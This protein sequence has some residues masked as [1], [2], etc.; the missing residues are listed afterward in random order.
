MSSVILRTNG[1]RES[2]IYVRLMTR[3]TAVIRLFHHLWNPKSDRVACG[4]MSPPTRS[5]QLFPQLELSRNQ[6][7][8]RWSER[9]TELKNLVTAA[10][11]QQTEG[12][13][14]ESHVRVERGPVQMQHAGDETICQSVDGW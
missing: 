4:T 13:E 3:K 10:A 14:H 5:G 2:K 7:L 6:V 11:F 1:S 8:N 12:A 9:L